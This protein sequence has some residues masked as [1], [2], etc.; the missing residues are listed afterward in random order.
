MNVNPPALPSQRHVGAV[1]LP[2]SSPPGALIATQ[3]ELPISQA[4]LAG[5]QLAQFPDLQFGSST[6]NA[7]A[8]VAPGTEWRAM[9][10]WALVGGSLL[11][12]TIASMGGFLLL[13]AVGAIAAFFQARRTR[14]LIHGQAVRVDANQL[15]EL[16]AC[17]QEFST[18]LGL[19]AAPEV[20]MLEDG[21]VNG[22]A[23]KLAGKDMMLLTDDAVWG[24]MQSKNP[25]ALGFI[26]AHELAHFALGHTGYLRGLIRTVFPPLQRLDELSADNVAREL[27]GDKQVAFEGIKLLTVGP[28]M[29]HYINDAAL[30][31]QAESVAASS[32]STKVEKTMTHP[33]LMRRLFNVMH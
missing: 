4:H 2:T 13:L 7:S 11:F 6:V 23:V 8:H 28:Q 31:E 32:L 3:P 5:R 17:V 21:A 16:H 15:P 25:R 30:R 24:A 22:F 14:A 27:V 33:L 29:S 1:T 18:R 9:I 19:Q 12:A 20:Y 10:G 26:V